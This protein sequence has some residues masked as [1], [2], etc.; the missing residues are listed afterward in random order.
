MPPYTQFPFKI[1]LKMETPPVLLFFE[2]Y[3]FSQG[4]LNNNATQTLNLR[5]TFTISHLF[6]PKVR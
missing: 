2:I 1:V 3:T 5:R 6:L 4:R